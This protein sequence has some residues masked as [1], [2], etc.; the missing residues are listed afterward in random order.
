MYLLIVRY[1]LYKALFSQK[2]ELL[3]MI[4]VISP[5]KSVDFETP[6]HVS[7]NSQPDF[8]AESTELIATLNTLSGDDIAKLMKISNELVALNMD[9]YK[10]W[11]PTPDRED[12]KQALL[13][14]SGEVFR[15]I[16][17]KG[18]SEEDLS[19]AQGH[20]RIL[21]GLYGLL[22][23]MDLIQPYR[24]EMGTRLQ[25][26]GLKNLYQ[27][28]GEKI[29]EK[30]NADLNGADVLVNLASTEYFKSVKPSVLNAKV[31]TPVFKDFANG[32]Y[33]IKM[34]Y[35]KNARG[36]MANYIIKN[37]VMDVELLKSFD[38]N[39]YGFAPDLSSESEWVFTRG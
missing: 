31:I 15:G 21:S 11:S 17:A 13:A 26:N 34:T 4:T 3:S 36:L 27:F 24:L 8:V 22:K 35:A 12:I 28:W 23:P 6:S 30:I 7:L 32:E 39:G 5:A 14:F 29:T 38:G 9:R 19:F 25:H 37:R 20:L 33:K 1:S 16:D 18:M 2:K 10:K